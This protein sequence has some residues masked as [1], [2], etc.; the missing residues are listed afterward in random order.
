MNQVN[1]IATITQDIELK[2]LANGSAIAKLSVA[3]NEKYKKQ[4]GQMVEKAH[5]FN[6]S[7]FGKK[8]ETINTYFNKGS[9]I[10]ITGSLS[11]ESWTAQDGSKRSNVSIKL[12]DFTFIDRKSDNQNQAQQMNQGQP[13]QQYQPT[14]H[15]E[16][17]PMIDV[18]G[19]EIPF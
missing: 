1:L 14:Q 16:Q 7:C 19:E 2:Y 17:I 12:S 18:D 10:G 3:Y 8:A 9:R 13:Q 6:V 15:Q 4:D 5:F 11:F